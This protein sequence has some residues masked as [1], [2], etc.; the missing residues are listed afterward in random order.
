MPGGL[1][2]NRSPFFVYRNKAYLGQQCLNQLGPRDP[3][4]T[5]PVLGQRGYKDSHMQNG[6]IHH[7]GT[8]L[9]YWGSLSQ[10]AIY[11][12]GS[13]L[14][15]V[16]CDWLVS[17][18]CWKGEGPSMSWVILR[19]ICKNVIKPSPRS[20]IA[21]QWYASTNRCLNC[22]YLSLNKGQNFIKKKRSQRQ[23]NQ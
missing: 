19:A 15:S 12:K 16:A 14:L 3:K 21:S 6:L 10:V 11:T 23:Q 13:I 9:T 1:G 7:R 18:S 22:I 8:P 17:P 5:V 4:G 20:D 2:P